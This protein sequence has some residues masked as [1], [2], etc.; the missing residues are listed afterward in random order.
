MDRLR[1]EMLALIHKLET[2]RPPAGGIEETTLKR[3]RSLQ[4]AAEK[5]TQARELDPHFLNLRQFWLDSVDWCSQLSRD[6]E[7]LL[8]LQ[9]ELATGD[10]S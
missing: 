1:Q 8:I 4:A 7:R 2:A 3:L 9:A 5:A 10:G 6:I